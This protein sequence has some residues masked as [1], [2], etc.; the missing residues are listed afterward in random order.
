[1]TRESPSAVGARTELAVASALLRAGAQVYVPLFAPHSRVNL[2]ADR[3]GRLARLQCKTA[4]LQRGAL[5]FKTCSNTAN[6]PQDYRDEVE[7]FGVYSPDLDRVY[8]VPV[9]QVAARGCHLRL[10]RPRNGQATGIRWADDF[11]VGSP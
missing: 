10:E 5:V 4:R 7:A 2:V 1:M 3:G 8:V 9:D 6:V 11:L